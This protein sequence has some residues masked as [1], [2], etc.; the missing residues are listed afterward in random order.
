MTKLS[1]CAL[2]VALLV[3]RGSTTDS[4]AICVCCVDKYS[5][6]SC[7]SSGAGE[8]ECCCDATTQM[9]GVEAC[10]D[11]GYGSNTT[12]EWTA[13]SCKDYCECTNQLLSCEDTKVTATQVLSEACVADATLS[14]TVAVWLVMLS[15]GAVA[16][17]NLR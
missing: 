9:E 14:S 3:Q 11:E 13:K 12:I 5:G 4:A 7:L 6:D 1:L 16:I 15:V 10:L 2:L 17:V 8:C